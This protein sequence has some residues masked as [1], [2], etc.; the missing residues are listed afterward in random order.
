M[1]LSILFIAFL[2]AG[3]GNCSVK[4]QTTSGTSA[5]IETTSTTTLINKSTAIAITMDG[6]STANTTSSTNVIKTIEANLS[7]TLCASSPLSDPRCP[8][9][10]VA[11]QQMYCTAYPLSDPTCP[12]YAQAYLDSQCIKDS[13]YSPQCKGYATAYAIKNLMPID[14]VVSN[15][16]NNTLSTTAATKATDPANTI[17]Q[18]NATIST[19]AP[20]TSV[21][22]DGTVSTGVS[23]TGN[24]TVDNAITPPS[25]TSVSPAAPN[26]VVQTAPPSASAPGNPVAQAPQSNQPAKSDGLGGDR[27]QPNQQA[28]SGPN[29]N[30][31]ASSGPQGQGNVAPQ[32]TARQAIAERRAEQQKMDEM[33]QGREVA[34]NMKAATSME[35]QRAAQGLVISAM[36]GYNPAFDLYKQNILF[37]AVGYRPYAIYVNQTT[38]D[39]RSAQ[40]MFGSN[41]NLH[42]EMIN[43]QYKKEKQND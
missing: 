16:I 34:E 5:L 22:S 39:N 40:Q 2:M 4:A 10:A 6:I 42:K 11:K 9:Y 15:A 35:Q 30:Q 29:P 38:V 37:D 32:P 12:G 19:T 13:L 31:P 43:S 7:L 28:Q 36:A 21:G 8:G 25:T 23:K 24:T 27:P 41:N 3:F 18:P 33:K 1:K 26:S 14:P 17:S 20:T